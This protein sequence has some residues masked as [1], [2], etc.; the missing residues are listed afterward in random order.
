MKI[1][2]NPNSNTAVAALV[3]FSYAP[4]TIVCMCV[5]S[6]VTIEKYYAGVD[7]DLTTWQYIPKDC[8]LD[9]RRR[10]N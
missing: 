10:E 3:Y 1:N 9:T 4:V 8:E 2:S 6:H 5:T 7:I